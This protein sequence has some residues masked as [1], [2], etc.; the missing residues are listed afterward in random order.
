MTVSVISVHR[1]EGVPE[2]PSPFLAN[3]KPSWS[4]VLAPEEL[5]KITRVIEK[6]NSKFFE[7]IESVYIDGK[8]VFPK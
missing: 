8:R 2:V 6:P 4:A 3:G 1:K 5:A 7:T